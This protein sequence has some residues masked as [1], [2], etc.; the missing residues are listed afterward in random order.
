MLP[1][2][3]AIG[4][5]VVSIL[6]WV[7]ST[8]RR[9]VVLDE[10]ISN[11]MSQIG[12]QLSSRFD[13]LTAL[14]DLTKGYAK[15]ESETLIETIKSRRS[16]ITAKSTPNDVLHQEGIISEALGRIAMVTEQYPELAANQTYIKT[17][18]AVEIFENMVRTSHLIYNDSVIKLNR[19]IRMFPVAMIAGMLGFGQREYLIEQA[20]KAD[21]PSMK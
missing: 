10:N 21:M 6:L 14:L 11:A 15:H 13:A 3:I 17:M 5:I 1:T 19:E 7:I 9:L 4:I 12:V 18:N 20:G 2:L 16:V 8:Q